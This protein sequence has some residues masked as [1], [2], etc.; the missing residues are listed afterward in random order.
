M[1][2]YTFGVGAANNNNGA[3]ISADYIKTNEGGTSTNTNGTFGGRFSSADGWTMELGKLPGF[4]TAIA[5][6]AHLQ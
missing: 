3:D 1:G 4:G 2:G 6:P 5:L